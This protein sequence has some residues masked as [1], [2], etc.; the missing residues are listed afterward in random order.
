MV[1]HVLILSQF[2]GMDAHWCLSTVISVSVSLLVKAG[3]DN[4][5]Y[6]SAETEKTGFSRPLYIGIYITKVRHISDTYGFSAL[7]LLGR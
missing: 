5:G 6:G 3:L 2:T 4:F 1:F 7:T